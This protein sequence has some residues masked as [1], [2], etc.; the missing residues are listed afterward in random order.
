MTAAVVSWLRS[1]PDCGAFSLYW[2]LKPRRL[3]PSAR[4]DALKQ[5]HEVERATTAT[6]RSETLGLPSGLRVLHATT[7]PESL[8]HFMAP[9]A[10]RLRASG[11]CVDAAAGASEAGAG[12]AESY[13]AVWDVPWSRN[14]A[15]PSNLAGALPSMRRLLR[16]GRYHVVHVMTPVAGFVTRLAVGTFARA[17]RPAVVYAAHGFHF[18]NGG[19]AARNAVFRALERTAAPWTDALCVVNQEDHEAAA[20]L[21]LATPSQIVRLHGTGIDLTR[22]DPA[23]VP[24][25]DVQRVRDELGLG[26]GDVL[27]T[28]VAEFT[29][30]KRHRDLL[31]ALALVPDAHLALPGT[32]PVLDEIGELASILGLADR[33]HLLGFRRDVPALLRASR[34]AVLVS[35]QEGLPTCVIEA[36]ALGVPVVGTDIR[37]TRD[38]LGEGGGWLVPLG[39]VSA[40]AAALRAV[41]SG[42]EAPPFP[43]MEP[44]GVDAVFGSYVDAYRAALSV[45]RRRLS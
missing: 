9:T 42:A 7:V 24:D 10:R 2:A 5:S 36:L 32:G 13:D 35:E 25:A 34:A 33:V 19:R 29:E 15:A 45:R 39:D 16:R 12:L 23:G 20:S 31:Q 22:F 37:G 17:D 44:F 6:A 21:G 3:T 11:H 18:Y 4:M 8:R 40:I 27:F 30:R 28:Q 38:L 43:D 1:I 14:P 41:A 26:P